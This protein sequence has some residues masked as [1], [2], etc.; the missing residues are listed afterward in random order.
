MTD[1]AYGGGKY[2]FWGA[3]EDSENGRVKMVGEFRSPRKRSVRK[4]YLGYTS[5]ILVHERREM[6]SFLTQ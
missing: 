2:S 3:Q 1:T 4:S 5:P 6:A